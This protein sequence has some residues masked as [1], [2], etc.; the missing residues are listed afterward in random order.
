VGE[1]PQA[2]IFPRAAPG[3]VLRTAEL[4]RRW[5]V[6]ALRLRLMAFDPWDHVNWGIQVRA[7]GPGGT[8]GHWPGCKAA[9]SDRS[10]RNGGCQLTQGTPE[11]VPGFTTRPP[12]RGGEMV[13]GVGRWAH[14]VSHRIGFNPQ[15]LGGCER[16]RA[17][18]LHG[19]P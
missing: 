5:T 17:G 2:P 19:M 18:R 15:V 13:D 1:A 6:A 7:G 3:A 8:S 9:P 10:P 14:S 12:G 16:E 11:A 4:R